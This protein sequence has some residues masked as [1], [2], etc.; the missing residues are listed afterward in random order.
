MLHLHGL[1]AYLHAILRSRFGRFGRRLT[2][3][4]SRQAPLEG[5]GGNRLRACLLVVSLLDCYIMHVYW[6]VALFI[7][8]NVSC[9]KKSIELGFD[10]RSPSEEPL[11]PRHGVIDTVS[12]LSGSRRWRSSDMSSDF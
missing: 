4:F 9:I 7:L 6:H 11:L 5:S 2:K 8:S 1:Q 3:L 10:C 12:D